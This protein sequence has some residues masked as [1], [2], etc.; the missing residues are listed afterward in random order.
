MEL[1]LHEIDAEILTAQFSTKA[2]IDPDIF[3]KYTIDWENRLINIFW[4]DFISHF[5]YHCFEDVL[6]FD[7]TY[8]SNI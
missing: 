2:K 5:D 4:A 1:W 6:A 7:A 8:K 3:Y